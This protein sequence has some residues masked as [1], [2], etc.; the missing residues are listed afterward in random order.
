MTDLELQEAMT[1]RQAANIEILNILYQ[2]AIEHPTQRFNQILA[3]LDINE[4]SVVVIGDAFFGYKETVYIIDKYHEEPG[5][6][7]AR[8][9]EAFEKSKNYKTY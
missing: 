4:T 6:T 2:F 8:V 9:K 3:N 5:E 1:P 7:L